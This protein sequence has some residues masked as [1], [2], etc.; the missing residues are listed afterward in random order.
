MTFVTV[1]STARWSVACPLTV[2]ANTSGQV[3]RQMLVKR[4]LCGDDG[5]FGFVVLGFE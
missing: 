1:F 3:S 2:L 5:G 4:D